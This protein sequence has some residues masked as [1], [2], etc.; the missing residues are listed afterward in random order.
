MA[1]PVHITVDEEIHIALI[2]YRQ[3]LDVMLIIVCAD[4]II[5]IRAV[6]EDIHRMSAL[7][8]LIVAPEPLIRL[9]CDIMLIFRL[10]H[11][12]IIRISDTERDPLA[13]EILA[14]A[15][16]DLMCRPVEVHHVDPLR[17]ISKDEVILIQE[18]LLLSVLIRHIR[19]V[20]DLNLAH[21][22]VKFLER[23]IESSLRLHPG[24]SPDDLVEA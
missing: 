2:R 20:A 13:R 24:L 14:V 7:R 9:K 19:L 11:G 17:I 23:H 5:R 6:A 1:S 22:A 4:A 12:D 18:V 10:L 3:D 16:E 21:H 15:L 8:R